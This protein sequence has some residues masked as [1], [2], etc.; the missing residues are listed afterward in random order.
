VMAS[1][2]RLLGPM[3]ARRRAIRGQASAR[4]S[5]VEARWLVESR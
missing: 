2:L 3:L 5:E 1:Y 4:R